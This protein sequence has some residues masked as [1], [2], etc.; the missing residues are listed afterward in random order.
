MQPNAAEKKTLQAYQVFFVYS[1][2]FDRNHG[3]R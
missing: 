1:I 2:F 3:V